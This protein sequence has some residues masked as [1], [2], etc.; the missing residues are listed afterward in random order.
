MNINSVL[1]LFKNHRAI[2]AVGAAAIGTTSYSKI[3][4]NKKTEYNTALAGVTLSQT[5]EAG[6][7]LA[8]TTNIIS[9]KSLVLTG[10]S[11]AAF[12]LIAFPMGNAAHKEIKASKDFSLLG[13]LDKYYQEGFSMYGREGSQLGLAL[14]AKDDSVCC[15]RNQTFSLP[16]ISGILGFWAITAP[17]QHWLNG[18]AERKLE[19]SP[20]SMAKIDT[21]GD[22]AIGLSVF[23]MTQGQRPGQFF[24][25]LKY[26]QNSQLRLLL[27]SVG[28]G[29]EMIARQTLIYQDQ[30]KK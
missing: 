26:C 18:L 17:I 8:K 5:A 20:S 25:S 16:R 2:L 19:L 7:V 11:L 29:T 10:L 22:A 28:I 13:K 24:K 14:Y 23:F 9:S 30:N 15:R 21:L 3:T 6:A 1:N 27:I 4:A 12:N